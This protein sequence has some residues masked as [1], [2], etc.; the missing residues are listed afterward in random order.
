MFFVEIRKSEIP[1]FILRTDKMKIIKY[2]II[3][4][5]IGAL[6]VIVLVW[7]FELWMF[8]YDKTQST[9]FVFLYASSLTWFVAWIMEWI[10]NEN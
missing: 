4:S 9:F 8:I 1:T 2:W 3:W 6:F 10:T 7:T 5:L